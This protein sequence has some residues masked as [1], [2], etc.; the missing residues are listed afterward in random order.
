M[1]LS[2]LGD[3][4]MQKQSFRSRNHLTAKYFLSYMMV[5]RRGDCIA[6]QTLLTFQKRFIMLSKET[7]QVPHS[8]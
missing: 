5:D 6:P 8:W 7:K 3:D 1:H 4:S 2:M